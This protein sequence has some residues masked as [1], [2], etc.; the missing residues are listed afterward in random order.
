MQIKK[1][2]YKIAILCV[3]II[4]AYAL[5]YHSAYVAPTDFQI[6]QIHFSDTVLPEAFNGFKIGFISD[7]D[8]VTSED[9]DYL[10]QCIDKI[11]AQE[12]DMV[13]FGGD[14][15]EKG[16]IFDKDR[17]ISLLKSIQAPYGKLA[18]LGDNEFKDQLDDAIALL[19]NGGFEVLRNRAHYIYYH[20]ARIT[21]AGL[22]S[23]GEVDSTLTEEQKNSFVLTVV[24][25]PDYFSDIANSSSHLQLSGHSGGGYLYFP[26][27]G[28]LI[29]QEGATTYQHGHYEKNEHHLYI[30]NGIG[31][32]NDQ[33]IRFNCPPNA[34]VIT[35]TAQ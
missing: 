18:V 8:L 21:L 19:E 1:L 32:G 17:M 33:T 11:N 23:T 12:C 7:F 16:T 34:L 35:L 26:L 2:L 15:Y 31:M 3:L 20:D 29:K 25:Q 6:K 5:W 22:E 28:G 27:L 9:F 4:G 10:E 24:H 13:I 30:S 14:L